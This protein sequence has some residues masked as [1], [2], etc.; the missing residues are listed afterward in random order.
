MSDEKNL[1]FYL[2]PITRYTFFVTASERSERGGLPITVGAGLDPAPFY[3]F[4]QPQGL[5]LQYYFSWK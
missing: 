5:P 4:G 1:F 2:L 3:Y